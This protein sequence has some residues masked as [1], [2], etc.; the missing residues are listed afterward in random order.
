MLSRFCLSMQRF[1]L[2]AWIGAA[3]LFVITSVAEQQFPGFEPE[4]RNQ[5]ATIRFPKYY[6]MGFV[7]VLASLGCS[8]GRLSSGT[9]S[10]TDRAVLGLLV[11]AGVTMLID[12]VFIYRPL[13]AMMIDLQRPRDTEF[14]WYHQASK[15]INSFG[16]L[17]TFVAAI[18]VCRNMDGPPS[19]EAPSQTNS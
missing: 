14:Q 13:H 2:S 5:L 18:L 19:P 4:I 10:K 17:L 11:L 7:V 3:V 12:F 1:L 15:Y 16:I 6:A 8:V 9:R